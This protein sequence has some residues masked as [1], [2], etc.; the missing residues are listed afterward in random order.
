MA[1]LTPAMLIMHTYLQDRIRVVGLSFYKANINT[2]KI[3]L[4]LK[5]VIGYKHLLIKVNHMKLDR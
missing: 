2:L 4:L 1:Y 5:A 3:K